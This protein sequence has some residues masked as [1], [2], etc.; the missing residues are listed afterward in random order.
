MRPNS[1]NLVGAQTEINRAVWA[2]NLDKDKIPTMHCSFKNDAGRQEYINN[3][4]KEAIKE[5][6]EYLRQFTH[7]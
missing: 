2:M 4:C 5:L 7:E 6:Q 3:C 1:Q